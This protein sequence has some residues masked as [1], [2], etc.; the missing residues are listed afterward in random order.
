MEIVIIGAGK[1][2]MTLASTLS[3]DGHD[4]TLIDNDP[5]IIENAINRNDLNGVV[6]NGVN[7]AVQRE[8]G[9]NHADVVIATTYS[10][11]I[12]MLCCLVAKKIGV[13]HT[14]ARIRDPEYSR[15]FLFML[16]EMGLDMV[17]NPEM[18]AAREISRILRYPY[19]I[20]V[21]TFAK[22]KVDLAEMKIPQGSVLD[23]MRVTD[24]PKKLN[25]RILV[26]AVQHGDEVYIPRGESVLHAGDRIH[27]TSSHKQ[28]AVSFRTIDAAR[29]KLKS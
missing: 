14:V 13:R 1:I 20:G 29:Q 3:Q 17:V 9:V 21:D 26:C 15:Q 19:A 2:G 7:F 24:I 6:G 12:N 18:E 8:A 25:V 4:I 27:F 22:G 28:P 5:E 16:D 23:G 10:D 11:E